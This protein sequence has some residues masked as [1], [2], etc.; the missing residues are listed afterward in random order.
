MQQPAPF[1]WVDHAPGFELLYEPILRRIGV[2]YICGAQTAE[3]GLRLANTWRF[4]LV[5]VRDELPDGGGLPLARAI[6]RR[7][8]LSQYARI[9]LLTERPEARRASRTIDAVVRTPITIAAVRAE[10]RRAQ[11]EVAPE[12]LASIR[13]AGRMN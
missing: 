9:V 11:G 2:R 5:L 1:L 7:S 6:R 3:H 12:L 13:A 4:D 8:C 10:L